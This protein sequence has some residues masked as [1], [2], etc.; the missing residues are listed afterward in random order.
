MKAHEAIDLCSKA[1]IV[2]FQRENEGADMSQHD[3]DI[4]ELF[5][6]KII[7]KKFEV[8][9]IDIILPDDLLI[10]LYICVEGNP[11]QFQIVL[12][13]LLHSIVQRKGLIPAGYVITSDDFAHAFPMHFPVMSMP[14][15]NAKYEKLWDEQKYE[16]SF[17]MMNNK[18]DTI[19]WWEEVMAK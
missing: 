8:F 15:V 3:K 10:I 9:G 19:E 16:S 18:C 7:L 13:D 5:T 17:H 1:L 6:S 11:G 4:A 14:E 2:W 12:K